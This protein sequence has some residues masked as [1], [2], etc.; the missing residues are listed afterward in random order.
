MSDVKDFKTEKRKR[1]I[2]KEIFPEL[3]GQEIDIEQGLKDAL[4]AGLVSIS[5]YGDDGEPLFSLTEEG[6]SSA[7]SMID[8]WHKR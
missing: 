5:G 4:A 2:E 8:N 6:K 7:E 3:R 1:I